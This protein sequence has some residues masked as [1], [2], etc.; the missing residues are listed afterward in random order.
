MDEIIVL[1]SG[2]IA[3]RGTFSALLAKKGLFAAMAAQQGISST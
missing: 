1:E 3:E 2:R